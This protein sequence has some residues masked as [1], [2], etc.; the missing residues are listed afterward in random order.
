[1]TI[2]YDRA[3]G[4]AK[5]HLVSY[6]LYDFEGNV[7]KVIE[8][9]IRQKTD[10]IAEYGVKSNKVTEYGGGWPSEGYADGSKEKEVLFTEFFYCVESRRHEE[11]DELQLWG[12]RPLLPEEVE[13]FRK[14]D[15][16]QAKKQREQKEEQFER[17]KKE[18]G[19]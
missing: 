12:E 16:E 5:Q 6:S 11:G 18:L 7:D 8:F 4:T 13:A 14:K 15:A 3:K 9:F 1:M 10:I 19:K 17:L 2:K